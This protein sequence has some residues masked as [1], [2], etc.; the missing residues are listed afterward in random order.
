MGG[1]GLRSFGVRLKNVCESSWLGKDNLTKSMTGLQMLK[2]YI[3]YQWME[4]TC[5]LEKY[6]Y[7]VFFILQNVCDG[8]NRG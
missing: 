1:D 5:H 4:K 3:F 6:C 8:V 7:L 2:I